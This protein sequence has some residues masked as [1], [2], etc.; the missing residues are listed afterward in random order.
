ME[1]FEKFPID[2]FTSKSDSIL[3]DIPT[4]LRLQLEHYMVDKVYRKGQNLFVEG[5]YPSGIYFLKEGLVKKY[6]T[7]HTGKEHILYLCANGEILGYSALLC[8]EPLPDSATAIEETRIGFIHKDVFLR[9]IAESPVLMRTLLTSLS[10]EFG[11]MVNSV[12]I[13]ASMTVR[14]R[15]A[16]TLL[17]LT[18]KFKRRRPEASGEITLLREDL[19]NMVGTATETVV[20][21]LQE[22]KRGGSIQMS[23][24]S[25][26][27]INHKELVEISKYY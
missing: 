27:V 15:L 2:K 4:E 26:I 18:E 24:K 20:R 6:K 8:Q 22:L 5:L 23:G 21:L 1:T 25:I 16:L 12:T 14:E 19:A 7:D 17:I 9:T 10:H 3:K 11:V 13:F